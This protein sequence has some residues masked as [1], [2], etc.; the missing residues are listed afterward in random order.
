MLSQC[1]CHTKHVS[2]LL[3]ISK[4]NHKIFSETE[5]DTPSPLRMVVFILCND[6]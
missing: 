2:L 4:M 5:T 3:F 6:L 1:M